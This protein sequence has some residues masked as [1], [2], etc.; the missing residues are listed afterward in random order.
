MDNRKIFDMVQLMTGIALL[1]GIALVIYELN[2]SKQ[3]AFSEMISEGFTESMD[4]YRTIMGENAAE[5]I[6]RS[7]TDPDSITHS[8][9][10]IL[11]AYYSS[12]VE[13]IQRLRILDLVADF[14]MRWEDVA[15]SK[16]STLLSTHHGRRWYELFLAADPDL[17]EIG[18]PILAENSQC[19]DFFA[20]FVFTESVVLQDPD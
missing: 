17:K 9:F 16:L 2:L 13:Q 15:A 8:D 19:D 10:V 14:G 20:E 11:S 5:V 3:L 6:A 4:N 12:E 7:C 1:I 18:D